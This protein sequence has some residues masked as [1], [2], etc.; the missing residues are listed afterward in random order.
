MGVLE[1]E[2]KILERLGLTRGES[3]T[4]MSLLKLGSSTTGP[5]A[6]ESQVSRS[7]LYIILD[8]L[9]KKG[10]VSHVEK[11]NMTY[12]Q[13]VEPA[14][15]KDYLADRQNELKNLENELDKFL[16]KLETLYGKF[17]GAQQVTI[18]QGLTGLKAAHE[19]TYLKLKKGDEYCYFGVPAYQPE[20]QHSYWMGDHER[21]VKAGIRCK[22]LFNRD[23]DAEILKERNSFAMCDARYMPTDVRP[24]TY[25]LVYKDTTMM[26]I[27]SKDPL[28]IE[29][30]NQEI[31]DS[32][33]VY[34]NEF[35]KRSR[36]LKP[37]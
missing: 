4:Y 13:A 35:W 8:K 37:K 10:F 14:K 12:F 36:A 29:I 15:I 21:R 31:A 1:L 9:E 5:I 16:P 22:L 27:P 2:E 17:G 32:F 30:I 18:Y 20:E 28:A 24:P 19:H 34:F 26:A 33:K 23:T 6:K 7:K 3:K 11:D 25:I